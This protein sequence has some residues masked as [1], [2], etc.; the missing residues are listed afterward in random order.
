VAALLAGFL[1]ISQQSLYS[2]SNLAIVNVQGAP[3]NWKA[4]RNLIASDETDY[5]MDANNPL[6][7]K[8]GS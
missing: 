7:A 6:P 8:T 1:K 5:K 4:R 3:R 2:P